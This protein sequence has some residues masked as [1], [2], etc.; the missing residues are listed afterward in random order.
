MTCSRCARDL[1]V[2]KTGITIVTKMSAPVLPTPAPALAAALLI[3]SVVVAASG[4]NDAPPA[5]C[6]RLTPDCCAPRLLLI[7][8]MKC[9]TNALMDYLS[10]HPAFAGSWK[11]SEVHF[12]TNRGPVAK[13]MREGLL[14]DSEEGRRVYA[15]RIACFKE[16]SEVWPVDKSPSYLDDPSIVELAHRMAPSAKVVAVLCDPAERLWKQWWHRLRH[17]DPTRCRSLTTNITVARQ[18]FDVDLADSMANF[19]LNVLDER[20]NVGLYGAHLKH[21]VDAYGEDN[22]LAVDSTFGLKQRRAET[23][24]R[25]LR[26]LGLNETLLAAAEDKQFRDVY[27]SSHPDINYDAWRRLHNFYANDIRDLTSLV[28]EHWPFT[29]RNNAP[30]PHDGPEQSALLERACQ[31]PYNGLPDA[32]PRVEP[33]PRVES[34]RHPRSPERAPFR[35]RAKML[36]RKHVSLRPEQ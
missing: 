32:T 33:T 26:F 25:V 2:I 9:G 21:W 22:V 35:I 6:D 3:L 13:R 23:V 29:W 4:V 31:L 12:F 15:S 7:G 20:L 11:Q 34:T 27:K 18:T 16:K 36:L 8:A 28:G 24:D 17:R 30:P 14:L 19:T 10:K 1:A 5:T